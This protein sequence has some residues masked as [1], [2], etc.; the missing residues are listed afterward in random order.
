MKVTMS[1]MTPHEQHRTQHINLWF[2]DHG[3]GRVQVRISNFARLTLFTDFD[4][5]VIKGNIISISVSGRISRLTCDDS[6][7]SQNDWISV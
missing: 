7:I 2:Y 4:D 1:Y 6:S 3:T 5:G